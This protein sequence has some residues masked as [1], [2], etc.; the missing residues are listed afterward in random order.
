MK[1]RSIISLIALVITTGCANQARSERIMDEI[2]SRIEMPEGAQPI[3]QYTRSYFE[4]G[5][6]IE[7]IYVDS[8]LAA[9]KGRYWNPE[10]TVSMEDGGCSQVR[11]TY[12]LITE[13][14]TVICNGHR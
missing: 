1:N 5:S 8:D 4:R 9:P 13:K 2:E 3:G 6:V 10:T 14:V 7:A 12:D 11:V